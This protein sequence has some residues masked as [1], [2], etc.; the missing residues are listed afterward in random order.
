MPFF[1]PPSPIE[2]D[3]ALEVVLERMQREGQRQQRL[4][5]VWRAY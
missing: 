2:L 5:S 4:Y 3:G 1:L